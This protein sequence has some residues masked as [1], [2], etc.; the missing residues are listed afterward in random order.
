M[1]TKTLI[2]IR[3]AKSDWGT[4]VPDF[5]RPLTEQGRHDAFA[6]GALLAPYYIDQVWC[7]AAH[8][9][10]ETWEQ[11]HRGGAR[12]HEIDI[13]KSFYDTWADTLITEM[14]FLDDSIS[15]LAIMNHQPTVGDLVFT[16]ARPSVLTSQ[17][18]EHFPTAGVAI[19]NFRG[20][21]SKITGQDL[22]LESFERVR[23]AN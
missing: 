19:L 4:G 20:S 8:R 14:T 12:V 3:H 18:S 10:Q 23:A 1:D 5:D 13:R 2:I 22:V 7:S 9:T 17:V 15:T 21:W 6:I 11:T 16:L